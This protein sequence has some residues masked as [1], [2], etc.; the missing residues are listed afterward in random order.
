[1][2]VLEKVVSN[3][4]CDSN[5]RLTWLT[6]FFTSSKFC[7][8]TLL[9]PSIRRTRSML[10]DLHAEGKRKQKRWYSFTT[11]TICENNTLLVYVYIHQSATTLRPQKSRHQ[12]V[13][14]FTRIKASGISACSISTSKFSCKICKV[15]IWTKQNV[16]DVVS[17]S[18]SL[19]KKL[20]WI[21]RTMS[22]ND[23]VWK[24]LADILTFSWPLQIMQL[25][26][27][28]SI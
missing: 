13:D 1:M 22:V 17:W 15:F 4:K 20:K 23:A 26:F 18:S 21:N 12:T 11:V 9:E 19:R 24:F 5:T 16:A 7:G 28:Q 8:R 27:V 25:I 6:N 14:S 3:I 2:F 10:A